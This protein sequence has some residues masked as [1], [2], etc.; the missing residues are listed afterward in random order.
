[1]RAQFEDAPLGDNED[2][3]DAV[4][5]VAEPD[6]VRSRTAENPSNERF[7]VTVPGTSGDTNDPDLVS[8]ELVSGGDSDLM[9]FTYNGQ[10][11]PGSSEACYAIFSDTSTA[12]ADNIL[13]TGANTLQVEFDGSF[14]DVTELVVGA[15][16]SGGCVRDANTNDPSTQGA[17]PAGGNVG[18]QATGYST[19]ADAQA[20]TINRTS[21]QAVVRL[22]QKIDPAETNLECIHLVGPNGGNITS[23]TQATVPT[24]GPGPQ[25][26]TLDF[27][28]SEIPEGTVGIRFDGDNSA[29]DCEALFTFDYENLGGPNEGAFESEENVDQVFGAGGPAL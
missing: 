13:V 19:G 27:G 9:V 25:P 29:D 18:A 12:Y 24:Q 2:V 20:L 16:D 3:T 15:A 14:S 7:A 6:A 11:D 22:D 5:V 28:A 17:K 21:D 8:T 4:I 26:L 1:M 10:I 23:P